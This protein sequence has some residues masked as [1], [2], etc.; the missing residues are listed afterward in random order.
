[1]GQDG[2]EVEGEVGGLVL[3]RAFR[4]DGTSTM[5]KESGGEEGG[6]REG[7]QRTEDGGGTREKERTKLIIREEERG[8]IG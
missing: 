3:G 8:S 2:E 1:M 6:H 4:L 5:V 7:E